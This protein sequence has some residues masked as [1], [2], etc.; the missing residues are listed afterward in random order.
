MSRNYLTLNNYDGSITGVKEL[1]A[2]PNDVVSPGGLASIQHH[3]TQ[4]MG[5]LGDRTSD[6]F[7]GTGE[8]YPAGVYGNLYHPN[9][10]ASVHE[11]HYG[12]HTIDTQ[13]ITLSGKPYHWE[14]KL[15]NA[16]NTVVE[17]YTDLDE[18]ELVENDPPIA[19][20]KPTP[21]VS[22]PITPIDI[23]APKQNTISAYLLLFLF[24]I[25]YITF[26]FWSESI[27]LFVHQHINKGVKS[28]WKQYFLLSTVTTVVFL[29][30]LVVN[31]IPLREIESSSLMQ[32]F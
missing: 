25:A 12:P 7:A 26:D 20:D 29:L 5:G 14:S 23:Q 2:G 16:K 8:R 6:V 3:W 15:S 28:T 32:P 1:P 4:G 31:D 17:N 30:L 24:L 11:R 19:T 13:D 18:F 9:S 22:V 21:S 10:H 27:H